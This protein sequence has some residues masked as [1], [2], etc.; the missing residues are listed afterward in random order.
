F[1]LRAECLPG[2]YSHLVCPENAGACASLSGGS[3]SIMAR[4]RLAI[5]DTSSRT[6]QLTERSSNG[7]RQ[8]FGDL[9]ARLPFLKSKRSIT[10]VIH[11]LPSASLTPEQM[12]TASCSR[13]LGVLDT[14]AAQW[15]LRDCVSVFRR[16]RPSISSV[17]L[18]V[19]ESRKP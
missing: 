12:I 9:M 16:L 7:W 14:K 17:V 4:C 3:Y 2:C 6:I 10:A 1:Y 11:N 13:N 19:N 15:T 18:F 5:P 8:P